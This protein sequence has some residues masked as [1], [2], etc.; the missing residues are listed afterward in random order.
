V[1]ENSSL[2]LI[3]EEELVKNEM[4]RING[5]IEKVTGKM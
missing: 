5:S 1:T 2:E 3:K 4:K